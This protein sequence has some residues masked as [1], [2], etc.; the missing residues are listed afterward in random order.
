MAQNAAAATSVRVV[1][2]NI[3]AQV[4]AKSAWFPWTPRALMKSKA[5]RA[6]V[7]KKLLAL[8]ADLMALQ[9]L[10]GYEPSEENDAR[11]KSWLREHGYESRYVQRTKKS[12]AKKDGS[13]VAWRASTFALEDSRNLE[14]N[15]IGYD[16]YGRDDANDETNE[17]ESRRRYLRDCV[18]NLTLLRRIKDGALVVFA[19]THLYWD[20]ECADVKLAQAKMLI[21]ECVKFRDEALIRA[22]GRPVHVIIGGD[23]NS[24]PQ[25]DVYGAM[26][27]AFTS[28]SNG[29][30]PQF[31]NVTPSFTACI[32]Y[33]FLSSGVR[34]VAV[35][36]QPARD[37]LGEGL[38]NT[39]HPSD[40]LPVAAK[41]EFD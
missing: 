4:Y 18:G 24:D 41:I 36:E 22:E 6:N 7:Q 20:P 33:V 35:D 11:W 27:A 14:Y 3:L 30:E 28:V 21:A 9:E 10:D 8:D 12:N 40:H 5:R 1:T 23:F 13:C 2:Y 25:S 32:D 31:T 29:R 38:P 34:V 15:D 39:A 37:T 26:N 19:S 17:N 16:L